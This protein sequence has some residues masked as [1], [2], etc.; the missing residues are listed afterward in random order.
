LRLSRH[1]RSD[2]V[3]DFLSVG[4]AFYG[5]LRLWLSPTS[6]SYFNWYGFNVFLS[7]LYQIQ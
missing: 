4:R 3:S 1:F 5:S 7:V 6:R 2:E